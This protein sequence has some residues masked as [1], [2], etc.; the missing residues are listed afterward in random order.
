MTEESKLEDRAIDYPTGKTERK[1]IL[2]R[3]Q[4]L[5][6][7]WDDTSVTGV[8]KERR[9]RDWGV[10]K[11]MCVSNSSKSTFIHAFQICVSYNTR[12][13]GDKKIQISSELYSC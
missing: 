8:P 4:R 13:K 3:L 2:K 6:N 11:C 5:R 10:H 1:K 12:K 9:R 7:L